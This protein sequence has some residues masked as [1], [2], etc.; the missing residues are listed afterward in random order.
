MTVVT[1]ANRLPVRRGDD[2]WEL[3]PG[4]LVT[5]LRPVM[6]TYAGAW[7]GWDGGTRG[8]PATLPDLSIR[9]LTVG[10][11]AVQIRQ[12]YHGSAN[13]TLWPLL[14]DAIEKPRFERAWWHARAGTPGQHPQQRPHRHGPPGPR[15]R[16][17][18]VGGPA[19]RRD[20]VP[21]RLPGARFL[22]LTAPS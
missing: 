6:A 3:S 2:G 18:P 8:I 4:R 22:R 19:G 21:R 14:H 5:A 11:S 10:L 16:R 17:A 7:V 1:I 12:Y 9:L 13:A 15:P 20:P